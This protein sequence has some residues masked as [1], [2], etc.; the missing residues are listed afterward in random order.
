[1]VDDTAMNFSDFNKTKAVMI[2]EKSWYYETQRQKMKRLERDAKEGV[3][4]D[5]RGGAEGHA[6][7]K[8]LTRSIF[9]E[10]RKWDMDHS[11]TDFGSNIN[12]NGSTKMGENDDD[13]IQLGNRKHMGCKW[14]GEND[15]GVKHMYLA[16][17]AWRGAKRRAFRTPAGTT[18]RHIQIARFATKWGL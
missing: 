14:R 5:A 17:E 18:P 2:M 7:M 10:Q 16:S 15:E 4:G 1:M 9:D 12:W 11:V 13:D 8:L 6:Y 3:D